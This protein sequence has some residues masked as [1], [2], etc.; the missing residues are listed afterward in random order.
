MIMRKL[1]G[2]VVTILVAGGVSTQAAETQEFDAARQEYEQSSHDEP[3]RL[4]YVTKLA[5]IRDR[6]IQNYWKT[7]DKNLIRQRRLTRNYES[8]RLQRIPIPRS[9]L[10]F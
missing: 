6:Q 4:A 3:A 8:I 2:I 7:G 1:V 5:K 9:C 10:N